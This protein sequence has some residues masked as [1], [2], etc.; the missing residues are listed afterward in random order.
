MTNDDSAQMLDCEITRVVQS[1]RRRLQGVVD[2]E[3]EVL[4]DFFLQDRLVMLRHNYKRLF[5]N[6]LR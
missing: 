4:E 6:V 3:V 5:E 2:I 1:W